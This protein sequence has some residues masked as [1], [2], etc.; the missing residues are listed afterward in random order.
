MTALFSMVL[1]LN[2]VCF[3]ICPA[4]RPM[5][6]LPGIEGCFLSFHSIAY[7]SNLLLLL[8]LLPL[9]GLLVRPNIVFVPQEYISSLL[10]PPRFP[11]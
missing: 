10:K 3:E 1:V 4:G 11:A 8:F 9:I 7:L 6:S 2:T 5:S